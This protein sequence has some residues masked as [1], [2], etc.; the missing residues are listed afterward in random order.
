MFAKA[1]IEVFRIKQHVCLRR[2]VAHW[3]NMVDYKA[4]QPGAVF[5]RDLSTSPRLFKI[6]RERLHI[7]CTSTTILPHG[8]QKKYPLC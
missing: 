3:E 7:A 1:T 5:T 6:S 8:L 2:L 4:A